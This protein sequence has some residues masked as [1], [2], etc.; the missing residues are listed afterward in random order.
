ME[1]EETSY[2]PILLEDL[3]LAWSHAVRAFNCAQNARLTDTAS[4]LGEI[5]IGL[6]QQLE[7]QQTMT[8]QPTE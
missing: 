4:A 6:S 1:D 7:Y 2:N 5:V 8:D 3:Q